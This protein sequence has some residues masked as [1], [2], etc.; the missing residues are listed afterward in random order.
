VEGSLWVSVGGLVAG[1]VPDDQGLVTGTREEHVWA[2]SL[3]ASPFPIP[4]VFL[5][6]SSSA[7]ILLH[8]GGQGGDPAAVALE[9]ALKDQLLSHDGD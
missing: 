4:Q 7:R 3:S 6:L 8:G 5:S 2:V 1:Q 9:G